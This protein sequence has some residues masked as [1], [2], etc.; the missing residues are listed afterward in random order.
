MQAVEGVGAVVPPPA[1]KQTASAPP[2][3]LH[4]EGTPRALSPS[5]EFPGPPGQAPHSVTMTDAWMPGSGSKAELPGMPMSPQGNGRS[6]LGAEAPPPAPSPMSPPPQPRI[7]IEPPVSSERPTTGGGRPSNASEQCFEVPLEEVLTQA[8]EAF[9]QIATAL[10]STKWDRRAQALKGITAVLKGLD[11]KASPMAAGIGREISFASDGSSGARGLQLRDHARCFNAACLILHIAL[12]DKVLPVLLAAHELYRVTFEHGRAAVTEAEAA[13]AANALFPHILAKLGELNIR[14]HESAC[15]CVLFTASQ[16][17]FGISSSLARLQDVIEGRGQQ[18]SGLRGQQK[19][20]VYYGVLQAVEMLMRQ[21]PGRRDHEGDETDAVT[22]WT[23]ADITPFIISGLNADSVTGARVQQ[24]ALGLATTVYTTLGKASLLPI[25]EQLSPAAKDILV[26]RFEEEGEDLEDPDGGDG[27]EDCIELTGDDGL[28]VFGVGLRPNANLSKSH[29][30]DG[31]ECLMDEILEDTGL[32][33]DGQALTK[34]RHT[35]SEL[36]EE[37]TGLGFFDEDELEQ[38][39][40]A[41][42]MPELC[43]GGRRLRSKDGLLS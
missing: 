41:T 35:H 5:E 42:S 2:T 25:L 30:T 34:K 9:G 10:S 14:L 26:S 11:I 3:P 29:T 4:P 20:R 15:S 36:D 24:A 8:T 38:L 21:S 23:P 12:R 13:R 22:T 28:C 7:D 19:M 1:Q 18:A 31:E 17:F 6:E 39:P 43:L 27:D 37:L 40:T 33:F 32:V 16:P